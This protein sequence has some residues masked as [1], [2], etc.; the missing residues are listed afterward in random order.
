MKERRSE[1]KRHHYIGYALSSLPAYATPPTPCCC[2][3]C[4]LPHST[5]LQYVRVMRH[6]PP[7]RTHFLLF[8]QLKTLPSLGA[9]L[10][11][12]L[13]FA[14]QCE[15]EI[16]TPHPPFPPFPNLSLPLSACPFALIKVTLECCKF[17][18]CNVSA[19]SFHILCPA[20]THCLCLCL[21]LCLEGP[22][23]PAPPRP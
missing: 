17:C 10:C 8:S 18:K 16:F 15:V 7:T 9:L 1:A 13:T 21:C 23:P 20:P 22:T 19:C 3:C 6:K 14:C 11:A 12:C 5:H 2:C 4:C